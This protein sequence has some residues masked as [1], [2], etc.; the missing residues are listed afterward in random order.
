MQTGRG[1]V[2]VDRGSTGV[3]RPVQEHLSTF[4]RDFAGFVRCGDSFVAALAEARARSWTIAV[5]SNGDACQG[6]KLRHVNL[7]EHVDAVCISVV[8]GLQR[9]DPCPF[10]LKAGR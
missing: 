2:G 5:V 1:A 6:E 3:R 10:S 8:E 9:S 4:R 7:F